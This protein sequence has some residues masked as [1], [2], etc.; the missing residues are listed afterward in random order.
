ME[1]EEE[2]VV[3]LVVVV[4]VLLVVV[5]VLVLVP[6]T[7]HVPVPRVGAHWD[8]TILLCVCVPFLCNHFGMWRAW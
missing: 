5:A 7:V 8:V 6:V 3:E 2:V 4:V 1:V